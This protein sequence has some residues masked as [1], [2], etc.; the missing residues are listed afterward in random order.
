MLSQKSHIGLHGRVFHLHPPAVCYNLPSSK[1]S[2]LSPA[3]ISKLNSLPLSQRVCIHQEEIPARDAVVIN[4]PAK[5][6]LRLSVTHGSQVADINIWNANNPE[7]RFYSSKTRQLAASHLTVGHSLWSCMP[8]VRPLATVTADSLAY[9]IDVDGAG[10]HDVIGSRCDPYTHHVMKGENKGDRCH[11]NL[12][13][14]AHSVGLKE[15][16]VHDVWN[17][18]MC[19]GFERK[20][21][22]Y[23]AK[24]SPARVGDY[25]EMVSH[26]D[27]LVAIG[28]CPQ[29]DVGI[30]CGADAEPKCFPLGVEVFSIHGDVLDSFEEPAVSGYEGNHVRD[31]D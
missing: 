9:G 15:S 28:A 26:I 1:S 6:I 2:P 3:V 18:F 30:P 31:E 5:H 8:Y 14:A 13:R 19:T 17:A 22:K 27:L 16:D 24:P 29:G 11:S 23:F 10:V 7:E 20:T 25:V 21:G 4:L 12:V